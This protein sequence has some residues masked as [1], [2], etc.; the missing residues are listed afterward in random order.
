MSAADRLQPDAE[1]IM[2]RC[3]A[4]ARLSAQPDGLTRVFLSP[5]QRAAAEKT[6][7]ASRK[8]VDDIQ[9][10]LDDVNARLDRET[11]DYQ[12]EKAKFDVNRYAFEV[13]RSAGKAGA[14]EQQAVELLAEEVMVPGHSEHPC[15]CPHQGPDDVGLD[16]GVDEHHP[17]PVPT[18]AA[19]LGEIGRAHV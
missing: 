9:G 8:Q 16:S 19:G 18:V 17:R 11:Q 7:A 3:D 10:K 6:V 1:R 12:F 2:E 4:L 14:G 5:Q 13:R 15:A